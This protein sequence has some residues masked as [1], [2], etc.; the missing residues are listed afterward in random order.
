MSIPPVTSFF[1]IFFN[2]CFVLILWFFSITCVVSDPDATPPTKL[3]E[4]TSL[5]RQHPESYPPYFKRALY[6]MHEQSYR[7]AL[8]DLKKCLSLGQDDAALYHNLGICFFNTQD[9]E[10]SLRYF[11]TALI[12]EPENPEFNLNYVRALILMKKYTEGQHHIE[13]VL[14]QFNETDKIRLLDLKFNIEAVINQRSKLSELNAFLSHY[15]MHAQALMTRARLHFEENRF[16]DAIS[17]LKQLGDK[18]YSSPAYFDLYIQSLIEAGLQGAAIDMIDMYAATYPDESKGML[19]KKIILLGNMPETDNLQL[20]DTLTVY[21]D[22]V[23]EDTEMHLFK[24]NIL[25]KTRDLAEQVKY[26][27]FL[28]IKFPDLSELALLEHSI[29]LKAGNPKKAAL[30]LNDFNAKFP[31]KPDILKALIR[32]HAAQNE[33]EACLR[34]VFQLE[35][36]TPLNA[37]ELYI[38][39]NCLFNTGQFEAITSLL[40]TTSIS[41][42]TFET[43]ILILAAESW[44]YLGNESQARELYDA[45]TR[46]KPDLPDFD[47]YFFDK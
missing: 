33:P 32:F 45:A 42:H 19:R 15:P 31:G 4:L 2:G 21:L 29:Y 36:T 14:P 1:T 7:E 11:E 22:A 44:Y 24:L 8:I 23:P 30:A 17:D 18:G 34:Y 43:H 39:F 25:T 13:R 35:K 5:I 40:K 3:S 20:L 28:K 38:K 41:G 46:L 10:T 26:L 9:Y 37:E 6:F 27:K 47:Y 16:E 12:K